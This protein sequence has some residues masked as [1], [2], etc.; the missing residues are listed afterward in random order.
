MS[1]RKRISRLRK[2]LNKQYRKLKEKNPTLSEDQIEFLFLEAHRKKRKEAKEKAE[3][4]EAKRRAGSRKRVAKAKPS[5][6]VP[7][8]VR[9]VQ[10]GGCSPR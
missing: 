8:S 9:T 5:L 2:S 10:G 3:K 7:Q 6:S 4:K 1:K